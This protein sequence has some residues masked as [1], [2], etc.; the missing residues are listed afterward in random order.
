M[1]L[2]HLTDKITSTPDKNEFACCIFL[3]FSKAFVTVNHHILLEKL[4]KYGFHDTTYKWLKNYVSN[5]K[6]F[7]CFKGCHSSKATLLCGVP[8]GSI[9][10]LL[11]FL[12][13]INDLFNVSNILS[14]I[15]YADDTTL[16]LSH[17]NFNSL[18]KNA[19]ACTTWFRLNKL[20]LNIKTSNFIIFSGKKSYLKD[21]SRI[22]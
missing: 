16:V 19:T 21:L 11:L 3:D 1:A 10:G 9:L 18:I 8:Q 4:Y 5:R 14:P 22:C 6:Q 12:I 20:S 2:I 13:Y 7:V 17:S 15:M